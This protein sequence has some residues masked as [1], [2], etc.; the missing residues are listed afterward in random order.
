[1]AYASRWQYRPK[2]IDFPGS[3]VDTEGDGKR[4]EW[5]DDSMTKASTIY[6]EEGDEPNNF[7]VDIVASGYEA[8]CP[9]CDEYCE[10][11]EVPRNGEAVVCPACNSLFTTDLPEHAYH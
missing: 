4:V 10:L 1:M 9:Q 2:G 8:T 7:G 11:I 5:R 3:G 6:L